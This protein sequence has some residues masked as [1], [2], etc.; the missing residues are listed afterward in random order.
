MATRRPSTAPAGTVLRKL[1]KSLE[2]AWKP[3]LT[4]LTGADTYHLDAA[5][6]ALIEHLAP[7]DE[8]ELALTVLG[9][10]KVDVAELVAAARSMPMFSSR[11]V[12]LLRDVAMLEGEPAPLLDYAGS[13]PSGSHLLIRAPKLDLRRPLHKALAGA[14]KVLEFAPPADPTGPAVQREVA[15]LAAERGL[16]LGRP[17]AALLA[18]LC[19]GDLQRV[20]TELDKLEVWIGAR[21]ERAV[22]LEDARQVVF[23]GGTLSGWEVADA[24]LARDLRAGLGAVRRLVGSGDEPIRIVGGLAWRARTLLQAKAMLAGGVPG[25]KV[26]AAAR[27][28]RYRERFLAGLKR[29]SLDELLAFPA[30]LLEADRCLKSRSLDPRAVLESLVSDLIRPRSIEEPTA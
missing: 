9:E 10:N 18:D 22:R 28:W 2:K 23:G 11:R 30:R 25:D 29:Y 13:P 1:R 17:V 3:G 15:A 7:G 21:E 12:V 8:S 16:E 6:R 24:V 20:T 5:Q 26:V 19:G 27:A 4:V 14:G